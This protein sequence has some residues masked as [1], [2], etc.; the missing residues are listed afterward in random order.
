MS[1]EEKITD[2]LKLSVCV[3][4]RE[5]GLIKVC[6]GST[7]L[8]NQRF[9]VGYLSAD[10]P[11][12]GRTVKCVLAVECVQSDGRNTSRLPTCDANTPSLVR[13]G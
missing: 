7:E 5:R 12:I 11:V 13:L 10:S 4:K 2:S 1:V 9:P 6:S 3:I 8:I